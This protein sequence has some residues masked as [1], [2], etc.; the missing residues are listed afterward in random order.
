MWI[1]GLT[2]FSATIVIVTF[3]LSTHAKFWSVFMFI[4]VSF[5]SLGF[6]VAYMWISNFTFSDYVEGT[7]YM[8]WTTIETYLL[9]LVCLAFVL[10]IDGIVLSVDFNRGGYISKMRHLIK[11]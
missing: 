5:L 4:A 2:V 7:T 9:V 6:Y 1:V 11:E 10:T 3:K 8:A